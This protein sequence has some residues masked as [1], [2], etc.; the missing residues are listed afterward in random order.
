MAGGLVGGVVVQDQVQVEVFRDGGVDE[1]EEPQELLVSVPAVGLG[2]DGAAGEIEGG[3]QAGGA[4]ADVVVGHPGRRR[5]E[6]G[7]A[8]G[9]PV[10]G[11]DQSRPSFLGQKHRPQASVRQRRLAGRGRHAPPPNSAAGDPP[12]GRPCDASANLGRQ[13]A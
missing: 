13:M 8:R 1:L 5:G 6:H 9:G 7:Q 12:R 10:E 3:E 11:L 4:V 2:D